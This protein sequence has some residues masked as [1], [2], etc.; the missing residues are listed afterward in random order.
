VRRIQLEVHKPQALADGSV[1]I[2]L[3][4]SR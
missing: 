2:S 3:E 1:S 4:R